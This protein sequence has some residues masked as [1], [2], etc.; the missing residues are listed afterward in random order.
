MILDLIRR[1]ELDPARCILVGDQP[2]DIAAAQAAG[3]AGH[4]F[5]GGNLLNTV[6]ALLQG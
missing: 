4:L 1:W 6:T 3:I 2:S 5:D